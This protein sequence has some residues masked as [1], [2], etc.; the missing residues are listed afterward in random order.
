MLL[1]INNAL[2]LLDFNTDFK[3]HFQG[4]PLLPSY[5]WAKQDIE[6]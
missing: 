6:R 5:S 3:L 1:M 2:L 4:V